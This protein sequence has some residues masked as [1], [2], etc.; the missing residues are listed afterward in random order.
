MRAIRRK[1]FYVIMAACLFFT[2]L[3]AQTST[4]DSAKNT[5]LGFFR[6]Y[7]S[8]QYIT[9]D[10]RYTLYSDTVYSKFS[11]ETVKGTYTL[12]GRKARYTLGDV[13]YLQNDS[14][15]VAAY[16]KDQQIIISTP[17]AQN[18]G[19]YVPLRETLDSLLHAYSANYDIYIKTISTD[20][21]TDTTGYIRLVR[22]TGDT[23]AVYNYYQIEFDIIQNLIRKV[24]FEYTEPGQGLTSTDEPDE[25]QRL[26]KNMPRNKTL[27]IEF[28]NYRFDRF[29][30]S[31]YSEKQYVWLEDGEYKP[32]EKYRNYQVFNARN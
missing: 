29:E 12:N 31:W 30:D 4:L 26:L 27:R 5:A 18:A 21:D 24:E 14:F 9:F 11:Y 1:T 23:V 15:L 20:P 10:V 7:D 16:H 32:V 8:L 17:P 19:S 28:T 22:K 3:P 13:D 6:T 2:E 25:G